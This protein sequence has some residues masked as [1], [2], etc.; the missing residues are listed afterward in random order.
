MASPCTD[1][2]IDTSP[3]T[4]KRGCRHAGKWEYYMVRKSVWRR[5]GAPDGFL[6]IGCLEARLGRQLRPND[7]ANVPVNDPDN[8]WNTPRLTSRLVGVKKL[9][10]VVRAIESETRQPGLTNRV[11]LKIS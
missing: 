4:G 9:M 10:A 3:C 1:C 5:A 7:F 2:G 8:P 6:C 11:F